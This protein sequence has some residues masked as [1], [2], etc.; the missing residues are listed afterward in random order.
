M[1]H[2]H[3]RNVTVGV[4]G[5]DA[6]FCAVHADHERRVPIRV[7]FKPLCWISNPPCRVIEL[8]PKLRNSAAFPPPEG[9]RTRLAHHDYGGKACALPRVSLD[10]D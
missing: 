3:A 5:T 7:D 9:I 4:T 6:D 1:A 10:L 8:R 2:D